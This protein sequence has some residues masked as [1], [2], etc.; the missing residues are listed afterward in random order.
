M[1]PVCPSCVALVFDAKRSKSTVAA[2][3]KPVFFCSKRRHRMP[4]RL[5]AFSNLGCRELHVQ[6][7]VG[8]V[9]WWNLRV[10]AGK[11]QKGCLTMFAGALIK[12]T[13]NMSRMLLV[14]I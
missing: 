6:V 13:K 5:I 14:Y 10:Y 4:R 7:F 12:L 1:V 3:V 11:I 8:K 9:Y 2:Q